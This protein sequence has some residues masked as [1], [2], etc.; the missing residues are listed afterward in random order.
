MFNL[1]LSRSFIRVEYPYPTSKPTR[2]AASPDLA[3]QFRVAQAAGVSLAMRL[4]GKSP[5]PAYRSSFRQ[6]LIQQQVIGRSNVPQPKAGKRLSGE[7]QT[8]VL[9]QRR[10]SLHYSPSRLFQ[11]VDLASTLVSVLQFGLAAELP[12]RCI[13]DPF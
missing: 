5:N 9:L 8:T 7:H 1:P 3:G 11:R 4:T 12:A 2:L 10:S 6:H 13:V